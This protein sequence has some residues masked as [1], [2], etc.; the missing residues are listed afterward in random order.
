MTGDQLQLAIEIFDAASGL[1]PEERDSYLSSACAGAEHLQSYV[2]RLLLRYEQAEAEDFLAR[3]IL[4]DPDQKAV[5]LIGRRIGTYELLRESGSGGMGV[6]YL[7]ARADDV[8]KK[9]VAVKLVWPGMR[10]EGIIRRFKQERQILAA[11]DH[12]N[13]ARLLDGG[14]TEEGWPYVVMEYVDGMPITE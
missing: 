2:E 3:P 11:L 9:E 13:I 7:A 5:G 14:A 1:P 10:R 4:P 12:P 6:V 8:Y